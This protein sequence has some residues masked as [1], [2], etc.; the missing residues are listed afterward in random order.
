[1]RAQMQAA[2]VERTADRSVKGTRGRH[3]VD[4]LRRRRRGQ[5]RLKNELYFFYEYRDT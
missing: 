5:G 1:M 3:S 4:L 2:I